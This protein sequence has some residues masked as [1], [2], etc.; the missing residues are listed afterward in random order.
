MPEPATASSTRCGYH[1]NGRHC[2]RSETVE[3]TIDGR[4]VRLCARHQRPEF[5]PPDIQRK[6]PGKLAQAVR[7]FTS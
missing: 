7:R 6:L 4:P 1:E 5:H 3:I 2:P